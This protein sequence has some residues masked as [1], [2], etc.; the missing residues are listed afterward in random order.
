MTIG[1][2][3][4]AIVTPFAVEP[5]IAPSAVIVIGLPPVVLPTMPV[6]PLTVPLPE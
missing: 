6:A 4:T 1:A 2:L 5:E 3:A